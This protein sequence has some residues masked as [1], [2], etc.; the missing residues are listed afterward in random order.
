MVA[1]PFEVKLHDEYHYLFSYGGESPFF[2]HVKENGQFMGAR[3]PQC[4]TVWLPPRATCSRCLVPTQ[5][6]GLSN[7][8]IIVTALWPSPAPL[9]FEAFGD[10]CGV[11]LV[12]LDGATTCFKAVI[13][14]NRP[15]A[16]KAGSRVRAVFKDVR[17]GTVL[18][19]YFVPVSEA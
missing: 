14:G 1:E 16:F 8:G 18:D 11:A 5:W 9:G 4:Q 15:G 2:R 19:F 10:K 12:Q 7:E 17:E 13:V 3:C 6:T